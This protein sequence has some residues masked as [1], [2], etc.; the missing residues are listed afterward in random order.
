MRDGSVHE[1]SGQNRKVSATSNEF[2]ISFGHYSN[3]EMAVFRLSLFVL[4]P[5]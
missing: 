3:R 2:S 4:D 5:F 1:R